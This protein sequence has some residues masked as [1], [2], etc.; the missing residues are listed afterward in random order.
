MTPI[1]HEV[2]ADEGKREQH[3]HVHFFKSG[4]PLRVCHS[5][6]HQARFVQSFKWLKEAFNVYT[7]ANKLTHQIPGYHG[8]ITE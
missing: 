6:V 4:I 5:V 2:I 1:R 7:I 8:R 3:S